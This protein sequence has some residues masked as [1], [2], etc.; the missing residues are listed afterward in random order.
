MRVERVICYDSRLISLLKLLMVISYLQFKSIVYNCRKLANFMN[1]TLSTHF[2]NIIFDS[3]FFGGAA[4]KLISSSLCDIM[5]L[6]Q[7]AHDTPSSP[8]G[9]WGRPGI[10][11]HRTDPFY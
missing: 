9:L 1:L 5:S 4:T 11:L 6:S 3:I 10:L 2:F 7:L 8:W